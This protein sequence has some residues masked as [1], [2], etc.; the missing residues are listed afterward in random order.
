MLAVVRSLRLRMSSARLEADASVEPFAIRR[1]ERRREL[2]RAECEQN[3]IILELSDF[4]CDVL[5]TQIHKKYSRD[6]L[7][8]NYANSQSSWRRRSVNHARI[9]QKS[10]IIEYKRFKLLSSDSEFTRLVNFLFV[11]CHRNE[12]IQKK[13]S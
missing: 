9:N 4:F 2:L 7:P 8:K 11:E 13:I 10:M 5:N 12:C 3:A 6:S 1:R